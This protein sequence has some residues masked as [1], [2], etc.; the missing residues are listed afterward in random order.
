MI[1]LDGIKKVY[2]SGD[3]SFTALDIPHFSCEQGEMIAVVGESGSGKTTLL[4]VLGLLDNFDEGNYYFNEMDVS[5]HSPKEQARLRN[6]EIGF[7]LQTFGL[8]GDY[9]VKDNI[10]LPVNYLPRNQRSERTKALKAICEELQLTE[11]L[12]KYP[13]QLSRGQQQ[14][15]AFARALINNANLILADEPTGNL[16][17]KNSQTV[18][19]LLKREH[20]KGKTVIVVTHEKSIAEQC[21][22]QVTIKD[23]MIQ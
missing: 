13:H 16:D 23:G 5:K 18:I 12:K 1:K 2:K 10:L 4:R 19:E 11:Q 21:E 22:R 14:R 20:A 15:V 8:I 17:S 6:Q 9:N 3:S 7:V